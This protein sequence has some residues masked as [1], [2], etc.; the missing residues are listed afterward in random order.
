MGIISP[1][2]ASTVAKTYG[3]K[4]E[5]T[6]GGVWLINVKGN[7]YSAMIHN[8]GSIIPW[9]GTGVAYSREDHECAMAIRATLPLH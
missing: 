2:A 7:D 4:T 6:S 3:R 8:D 9:H 5:P 1:I